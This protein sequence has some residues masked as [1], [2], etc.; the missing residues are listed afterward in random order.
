MFK[1][2]KGVIDCS[3][4]IENQAI[5][6]KYIILHNFRVKGGGL[7]F[8]RTVKLIEPLNTTFFSFFHN[9]YW[10]FKEIFH[11]EIKPNGMI[12]FHGIIGNMFYLVLF[13]NLSDS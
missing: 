1:I 3:G 10:L 8:L 6:Y 12:L 2:I 7:F 9:Y 13:G 11:G 5:L 4:E